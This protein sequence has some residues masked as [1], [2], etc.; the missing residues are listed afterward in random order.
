MSEVGSNLLLL[1]GSSKVDK[2]TQ[3]ELMIMAK[4]VT[5]ATAAIINS[6]RMAALKCEDQTLQ[7]QLV[8]AAKMTPIATQT[9]ITCTKLLGPS[10]DNQLCRE[11][12]IEACELVTQ[13]G[14][15]E[16]IILAIQVCIYPSVLASYSYIV[17][18]AGSL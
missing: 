16:K 1:T 8:C 14:A 3:E 18:I 6:A 15:V 2:R 17:V 4:A 10:I 5:T 12:L 9:L 11:Q 7:N 13:V